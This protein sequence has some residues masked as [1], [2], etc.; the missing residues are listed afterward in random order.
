MSYSVLEKTAKIFGVDEKKIADFLEESLGG[1]AKKVTFQEDKCLLIFIERVGI[2]AEIYI[3]KKIDDPQI[4]KLP[5]DKA[6]I[7][8]NRELK[9]KYQSVTLVDLVRKEILTDSLD[10]AT[11]PKFNELPFT[12]FRHKSVLKSLLELTLPNRMTE[13]FA[14]PKS[15]QQKKLSFSGKLRF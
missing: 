3:Y 7:I 11:L 8:L 2:E 5:L 15:T 13:D 1:G 12:F 9:D 14:M 4:E 6:R 10:L